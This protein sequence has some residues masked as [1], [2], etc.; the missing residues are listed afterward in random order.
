MPMCLAHSKYK[1]YALFFFF[2]NCFQNL[3]HTTT[4]FSTVVRKEERFGEEKGWNPLGV[5]LVEVKQ[6]SEK[7]GDCTVSFFPPPWLT[8]QVVRGPLFPS[9][10]GPLDAS[11]VQ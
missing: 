9:L 10:A 1:M 2:F 4:S 5:V 3:S 8:G 11:A 6:F 7:K